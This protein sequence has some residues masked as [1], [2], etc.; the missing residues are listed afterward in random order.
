MDDPIA[1]ALA[2]GEAQQQ[3]SGH[4]DDYQQDHQDASP[5][6]QCGV[7]DCDSVARNPCRSCAYFFLLS[8]S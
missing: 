2:A 4:E 1:A 7:N 6:N 5:E 3:P 8:T